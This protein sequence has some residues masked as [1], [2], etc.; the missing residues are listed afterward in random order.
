MKITNFKLISKLGTTVLN[1]RFIATVDV[2]TGVFF[3]TITTKEIQR[4]YGGCWYF[5]NSGR[6]TPDYQVEDLVR[7]FEAKHN[8]KLENIEVWV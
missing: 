2:T 1:F 7:V 5:T 8:Q 3:K 4:D 6:F